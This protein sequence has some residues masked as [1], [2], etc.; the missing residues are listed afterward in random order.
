MISRDGLWGIAQDF[1]A[2]IV[3]PRYRAM[4]CFGTGFAWV[5]VDSARQWCP[6]GLDGQLRDKPA[7]KTERYTR[8]HDNIRRAW[9][10]RSAV[11]ARRARPGCI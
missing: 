2:E 10:I 4:S 8:P 6:V 3:A 5:P 7:C 11:P 1:G 9:A